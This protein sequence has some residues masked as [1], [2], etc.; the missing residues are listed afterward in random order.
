MAGDDHGHGHNHGSG[1]GG[2]KG[3][4]ASTFANPM[5]RKSAGWGLAADVGN[6][7]IKT[8]DLKSPIAESALRIG[9]TLPMLGIVTKHNIEHAIEERDLSEILMGSLGGSLMLYGAAVGG[10]EGQDALHSGW[11][12][13]LF[14]NISHSG[15]DSLRERLEKAVAE[16]RKK[17]PGA[18]HAGFNDKGDFLGHV[19]E[20]HEEEHAATPDEHHDEHMVLRV[21]EGNPPES[22]S[23][24]DL[25]AGDRILIDCAKD[26]R[27][28]IDGKIVEIDG[29]TGGSIEVDNSE[30]NG[31]A[32][33]FLYAKES[34]RQ[35]A[36]VKS[37]TA[38][39]MLEVTAEWKESSGAVRLG[40]LIASE[41]D[42]ADNEVLLKKAVDGYALAL[43]GAGGLVFFKNAIHKNAEGRLVVDFSKNHMKKSLEDTFGFVLSA[44]PCAVAASMLIYEAME[45]ELYGQGTVVNSRRQLEIAEKTDTVVL[46][47]IGTLTSG[48]YKILD[49][50]SDLDNDMLEVALALESG[51]DHP[52]AKALKVR[53]RDN[54]IAPA[55][56]TIDSSNAYHT[57][58]ISTGGD[59]AIGD[60]R[61]YEKQN[62]PVTPDD[63]REK[64]ER[65]EQ[66]G[67]SVSIVKNGERFGVIAMEVQL[68]DNAV[69]VVEELKSKGREVY[70]A[71]GNSN[72]H[73]VKQLAGRLGI[74]GE[75]E[76]LDAAVDGA[77]LSQRRVFYGL[78][79]GKKDGVENTPPAAS[80]DA[81]KDKV[82]LV[83]HLKKGLHKTVMM[84]G[85]AGNDSEAL[86]YAD[87]GVGIGDT[88][89]SASIKTAGIF[90]KELSEI[91]RL[92]VLSQKVNHA[93]KRN[94]A[95]TGIWVG[96]LTTVHFFGAK[97]EEVFHLK[98]GNTLKAVLHEAATVVATAAG[99]GEGWL[100]AQ[101]FKD[102]K[103]DA[104][105]DKRNPLERGWERMVQAKEIENKGPAPLT[106]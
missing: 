29:K 18:E 5:V 85:D 102:K 26:A 27:I 60:L 12:A 84:G 106:P 101:E 72:P 24:F 86:S 63:V 32:N 34:V 4:F 1:N 19:H 97:I 41:H 61:F 21:R 23:V 96:L 10:K 59:C 28:P 36:K 83:H 45:R 43:A 89:S 56:L 95:L 30:Y 20:E 76:A 99:V 70:I 66:A 33:D 46:D 64:A 2:G 25:S 93:A 48:E 11:L 77:E 16:L 91:A 17:I 105:D 53:A 103:G 40:K 54:G 98:I 50:E 71:T 67:Y 65:L 79:E 3:F 9:V 104:L 22:V 88:G 81:I 6:L 55:E 14:S 58:I 62:I 44:A 74:F 87:V 73:L 100:L 52:I 31:E 39:I 82:S 69:T 7:L 68:R 75:G 47:L 8:A 35:M 57:G 42:K 78:T 94:L 90:T 51:S 38:Q 13:T 80:A 92:P 49:T 15:E 37:D